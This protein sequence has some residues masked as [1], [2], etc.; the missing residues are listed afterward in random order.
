VEG[1]QQ[2]A[3]KEDKLPAGTRLGERITE[4]LILAMQHNKE[5]SNLETNTGGSERGFSWSYAVSPSQ[6]WKCTLQQA[7]TV[8]FQI[9]TYQYK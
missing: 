8:S 6:W 2:G 3:E 9:P 1:G 4:K 7:G 5:C